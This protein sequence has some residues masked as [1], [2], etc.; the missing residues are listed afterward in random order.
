MLTLALAPDEAP[1]ADQSGR[2]VN[3][4][5]DD[6]G[7]PFAHAFRTGNACRIVWQGLGEF[8]FETDRPV[9]TAFAARG[10]SDALVR[11]MFLR[12]VQPVVLQAQGFQT[13][14]ASAVL[15]PLGAL[16]FC[17]V[18]HSGKSTL[19]YATSRAPGYRQIAD[20]S[21]VLD[22]RSDGVLATV[23]AVQR[24]PF[25]P[26]LRQPSLGYFRGAATH[27]PHAPVPDALMTG[28]PAPLRAILVL[29]QQDA[30]P[31]I[32]LPLRLPP[33][34][35]FRELLRHAHCFDDGDRR[36]SRSLVEDYLHLAD[37]V[38]VYRVDYRADI[39]AVDELVDRVLTC[40]R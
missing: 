17:G 29:S 4:W 13:L 7:A 15:G 36:H 18:G 1:P 16:A 8:H 34:E 22:L 9:V 23:A 19:A 35:S 6:N 33:A 32:P 39:N 38:P 3:V 21:V 20:D 2:L 28:D 37:I 5:K 27:D 24:L 30:A 31:V 26:K 25:R 10:V 12:V 11:D 14:H 40:L